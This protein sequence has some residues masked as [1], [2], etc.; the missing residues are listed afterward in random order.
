MKKFPKSMGACADLLFDIRTKRLA[1]DKIAEELKGQETALKNHIIDNLDK[2][3]DGAIGKHHMVR[4]TR[5]PKPR[6]ITEKWNEFFAWVSKNKAWDV[7]QKRLSDTAVLDRIEAGKRIPGV[8]IFQAID[9]SLT[10]VPGK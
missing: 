9:V 8:E 6:V 5:K 2:S 4:V 7:V 3:S 10:K 1:A